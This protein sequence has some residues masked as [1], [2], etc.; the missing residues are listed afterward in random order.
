MDAKIDH[1]YKD[2]PKIHGPEITKKPVEK[3]VSGVDRDK[4]N[5]LKICK[6]KFLTL[7]FGKFEYLLNWSE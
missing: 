7:L 3:S 1:R 2:N 5:A 4:E 6:I